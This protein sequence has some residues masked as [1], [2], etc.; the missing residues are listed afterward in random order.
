MEPQA[1]DNMYFIKYTRVYLREPN[2]EG[3]NHL[4]IEK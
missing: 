4:D 3:E 2:A 1:R